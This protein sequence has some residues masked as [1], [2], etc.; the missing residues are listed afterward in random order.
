M[1]PSGSR[2]FR[3]AAALCIACALAPSVHAEMDAFELAA[4]HYRAGRWSSAY[5]TFL[6]LAHGGDEEATRIVRFMH[7]YGQRIYG[8]QWEG[9]VPERLQPAGVDVQVAGLHRVRARSRLSAGCPVSRHDPSAWREAV[10]DYREGRR[11]VAYQRFAALANR[12]DA[13]AARVVFFM[14]EHGPSLHGSYWYLPAAGLRCRAALM[15]DA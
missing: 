12:G 4:A 15:Q 8:S 9:L 2:L 7:R 13:D 10:G 11:T 1:M 6:Q 14:H 5:G 3:A